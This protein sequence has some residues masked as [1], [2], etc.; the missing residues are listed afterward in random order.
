LFELL[1]LIPKA[2]ASPKT[3]KRLQ[4]E[5]EETLDQ[6]IGKRWVE[7]SLDALRQQFPIHCDDGGKPYLWCWEQHASLDIPGMSLSE[8]QTL[9]LVRQYLTPLLPPSQLETLQALFDHA[10]QKIDRHQRNN[11]WV[12]PWRDKVRSV[13]AWQPLLAPKI[14][15]VVRDTVCQ[16]L[17]AEKQLQVGYQKPWEDEPTEYVIHPLGLIQRGVSI[18]LVCLF[19]GFDD[20]RL[21]A[22]HRIKSAEQLPARANRPPDFQLDQAIAEGLLGMG[23]SREPI[24]LVA[25]FYKPVAQHL[26]DTPL[27]HD[28]VVDEVDTYHLQIAATVRHTAQ[29]EWW[30][31]SFGSEVEVLEP[32]ELREVMAEQVRWMARKYLGLGKRGEPE[33]PAPSRQG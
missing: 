24:R 28:Q 23:G 8:A 4:Q 26:L 31:R 27:S 18:Y 17:L 5:L 22:L 20:P 13:P 16:A 11:P 21:L 33:N 7:R 2:P 14:D 19:E 32:A 25:K 9:A 12:L 29:L 10:D 1:K 3:A 6:E 15:P 30:L